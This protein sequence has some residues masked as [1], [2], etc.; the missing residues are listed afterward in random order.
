MFLPYGGVYYLPDCMF[1]YRQTE[2]STF[3]QRSPYQNYLLNAL[4]LY[5]QKSVT[6]GFFASG[7]VRTIYEYGQLYTNRKDPQLAAE[8]QLFLPQFRQYHAGRIIRLANYSREAL[9]LRVWCEIENRFWFFVTKLCRHF[10]WKPKVR[11]LLE[12]A[13]IKLGQ[14]PAE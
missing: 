2:G 13:R 1:N 8:A 12:E 3:H 14:Q 11:A 6:T 4:M 5:Q 10:I 9:P 7:L